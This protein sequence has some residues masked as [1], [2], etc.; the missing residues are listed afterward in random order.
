MTPDRRS[1][2]R[3]YPDDD[4]FFQKLREIYAMIKELIEDYEN[5]NKN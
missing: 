5:K 4:Y 1:T 3:A 2:K